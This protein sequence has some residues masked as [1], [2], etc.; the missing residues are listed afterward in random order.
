[1]FTFVAMHTLIAK[2]SLGHLPKILGFILLSNYIVSH[3]LLRLSKLDRAGF[4]SIGCASN[5]EFKAIILFI[6]N[7]IR[8]SN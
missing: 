7:L 5:F 2:S 1:M 6:R 3:D 4:V 8:I